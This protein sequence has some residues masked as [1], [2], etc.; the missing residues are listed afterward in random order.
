MQMS[1]QESI[2]RQSHILDPLSGNSVVSQLN[3][4]VHLGAKNRIS[5][6][7]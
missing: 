7:I 3:M 5:K 6:S 1:I 2:L 4:S